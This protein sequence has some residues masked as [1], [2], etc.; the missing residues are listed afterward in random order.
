MNNPDIK[1]HYTDATE[2]HVDT[3]I[4]YFDDNPISDAK[5]LKLRINQNPDIVNSSN[6]LIESTNRLSRKGEKD[7][8][9]RQSLTQL[10]EIRD[11]LQE[12]KY[13]DLKELKQDEFI[14][15]KDVLVEI[16]DLAFKLL[17]GGDEK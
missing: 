3:L 8:S 10:Q 16:R 6:K 15:A 2:S 9:R 14:E 17:H 11:D 5:D 12:M 1:S 4:D 7:T 13:D